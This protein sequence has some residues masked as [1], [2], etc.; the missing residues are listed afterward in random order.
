[1]ATLQFTSEGRTEEHTPS[2]QCLSEKLARSINRD[3]KLVIHLN[4]GCWN[5]GCLFRM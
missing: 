1:M 2:E 3:E 4:L 5:R